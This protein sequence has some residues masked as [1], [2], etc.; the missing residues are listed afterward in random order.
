V[1]GQ[2]NGV[3]VGGAGALDKVRPNYAQ[4]TMRDTYN[5]NCAQ[6]ESEN[7]TGFSRRMGMAKRPIIE[8][9]DLIINSARR[10]TK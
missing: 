1:N 6:N 5:M 10:I 8:S 3:P 9:A 7:D 2:G 4:A